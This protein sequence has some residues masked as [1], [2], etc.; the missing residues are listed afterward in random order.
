VATTFSLLDGRMRTE[1]LFAATVG[2][3]IGVGLAPARGLESMDPSAVLQGRK[4]HAR[5]MPE[6]LRSP[7]ITELFELWGKV[8]QAGEDGEAVLEE[9][10]PRLY[11]ELHRLASSYLSRERPG[12][13]LQPTALVNEAF[14]RLFGS[15]VQPKDRQHFFALA[16]RLMRRVLVDHARRYRAGRRFSPERRLTLDPE[17][18]E[19][20][21]APVDVLDLHRALEGF[22]EVSPRAA[23]VVELRY[24]GGLTL[25]EIGEVLE[26]SPATAARD[27]TA[28]RLWLQRELTR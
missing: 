4:E 5:D 13:T 28:A 20:A 3:L 11:E 8:G 15:A 2:A 9:L 24:F 16:A 17:G 22:A 19:A 27:W 23:R 1:G 14:L 12:H 26:V 7:S 18:F 6:R 21:Q 10:V 25:D